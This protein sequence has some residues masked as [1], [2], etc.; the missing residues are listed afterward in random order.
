M[1]LKA[2]CL[3][4]SSSVATSSVFHL[5]LPAAALASGHSNINNSLAVSTGQGT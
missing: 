1:T 5:I 4:L 3:S 2:S